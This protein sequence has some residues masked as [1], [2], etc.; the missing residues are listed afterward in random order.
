LYV[1]FYYNN[2]KNY[3]LR[4][5][6][7]MDE[8]SS[9]TEQIYYKLKEMILYGKIKSGE[10]LTVG[11]IAE[12]YHISRTPVREAFTSL[13]HDGLLEVL[14]HKG[15]LV[16]RI[17]LKDLEDLFVIR[18]MLEGGVAELAATNASKEMIA[19]LEQLAMVEYSMDDERDEIFFMKTNLNFHTFVAKASKNDRVVNLVAN[20]LNLMQRVLLWDLKDSSLYSMQTEH[21][22]LVE[23]IGKRDPVNTKKYMIEHIESSRSRIFSRNYSL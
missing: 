2:Q 1:R 3:D 22:K 15:Y 14:P 12:N 17:D 21:M 7:G 23:L 10:L 4:E 19:Q 20:T 8:K 5:D 18:M 13:K 9:L 11:E 6:I 16:S